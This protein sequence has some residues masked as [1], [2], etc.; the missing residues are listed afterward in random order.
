MLHAPLRD[1]RADG[2]LQYPRLLARVR[3]EFTVLAAIL[4]PNQKKA[5]EFISP[6]FDSRPDFD[7]AVWYF[8]ALAF[9]KLSASCVSFVSAAFSSFSVSSSGPTVFCNPRLR[10]NAASDPYSAIS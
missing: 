5:G 10:A 9:N 8:A 3:N 4:D 6:A 7:Q 2:D 1:R